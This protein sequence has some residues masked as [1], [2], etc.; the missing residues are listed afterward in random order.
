MDVNVHPDITPIPEVVDCL[1][2][3]LQSVCESSTVQSCASESTGTSND[4]HHHQQDNLMYLHSNPEVQEAILQF[5]AS[6]TK[7]TV[8]RCKTCREVRPVFYIEQFSKNLPPGQPRPMHGE[9]WRLDKDVRCQICVKY[10]NTS[11]RIVRQVK[12]TTI[13]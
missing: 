9:S 3:V 12:E 11:R 8:A 10:I 4:S 1:D 6:E 2:F 5:E 7:H 13:K